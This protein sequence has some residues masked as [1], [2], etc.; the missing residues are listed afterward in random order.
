M[1]EGSWLNTRKLEFSISRSKVKPP[2][3]LPA[4]RNSWQRIS[5]H[6]F[7]ATPDNPTENLVIMLHKV[8]YKNTICQ[9]S[10]VPE[11]P[12]PRR[13]LSLPLFLFIIF[14]YRCIWFSWKYLLGQFVNNIC[15]KQYTLRFTSYNNKWVEPRN[16]QSSSKK[17]RDNQL[18]T[19][20]R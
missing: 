14:R 11:D 9:S 1:H 16:F 7:L 19:I 15:R 5:P 18:I 10:V 12:V 3:T 2:V 6:K 4:N 20:H 17:A 13:T 8:T